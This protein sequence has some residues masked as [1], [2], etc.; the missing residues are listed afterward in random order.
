MRESS[1]LAKYLFWLVLNSCSLGDSFLEVPKGT[2]EYSLFRFL[3]EEVGNPI[4]K[5]SR[6]FGF[7]YIF[8]GAKIQ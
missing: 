2:A 6:F 5:L 4:S 8:N 7:L 1:Y 3:G